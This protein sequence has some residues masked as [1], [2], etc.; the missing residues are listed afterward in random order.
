MSLR[1]LLASFLTLSLLA[2]CGRVDLAPSATPLSVEPTATKIFSTPT[3][4]AHE[5]PL[6]LRVWVSPRFDPASNSKLQARL[7]AFTA[8]HSGLEIEVRVKDE[9]RLVES[10][11]LTALAAPAASP[12]LIA[13]S[14]ADLEA[15]AAQGLIQ[16]LDAAAPTDAGWYDSAL[17]LGRTRN[18]V[19]GRPF[20][21]DAL[22]LAS[23]AP[24]PFTDWPGI[25]E[26]GPLSFNANDARFPLALYLSVGGEL[27]DAQ[28]SPTL[29]EET[30]T[31]VLTLFA[32]GNFVSLNSD[33]EV[34]SAVGRG[35]IGVGWVSGQMGGTPSGVRMDALPGLEDPSATLVDGWAW[36][37]AV[38]DVEKQALAVELA[39]W[40]T[41]E[42]FLAEWVPSVGYLSPRVNAEWDGLL[43]SSRLVPAAPFLEAILPVLQEAVSSVLE[44][45]SPE[46]AART[47]VERLK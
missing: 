2:A 4:A 27:T 47:A 41:D 5:T 22:T 28:G 43:K 44:D 11:R 1:S 33:K 7:D 35:G 46:D 24:Q 23:S 8:G 17:A 36:T 26:A 21:L 42:E 13:L 16:P 20:A 10:L 39:A 32:Q 29:D 34:W 38:T 37:V 30:L 9:S 6:V 3:S 40:L 25:A 14:H 31:R 12:D 45:V 18:S 19:Y 15:A